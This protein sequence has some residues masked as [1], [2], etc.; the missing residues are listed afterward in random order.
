M[1]LNTQTETHRKV[2]YKQYLKVKFYFSTSLMIIIGIVSIDH[3]LSIVHYHFTAKKVE[4]KPVNEDA[5]DALREEIVPPLNIPQP[6]ELTTEKLLKQVASTTSA[7]TASPPGAKNKKKK[8][9]PNV[10]SLMG[11][12]RS[13]LF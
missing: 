9:E 12:Y 11:E 1:L 6:T 13:L 10:L 5:V 8:P 2:F 7:N 4:K 3:L